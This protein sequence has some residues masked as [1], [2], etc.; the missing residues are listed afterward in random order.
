MKIQFKPR[1]SKIRIP[2]LWH[3]ARRATKADG[4][5]I[6]EVW[7]LAHDMRE[8][9]LDVERVTASAG[10]RAKKPAPVSIESKKWRE[11]LIDH[12]DAAKSHLP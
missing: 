12:E 11:D 10:N 9:L 7:H 1:P 6:L 5:L 4:K 3:V 2:D 8:A